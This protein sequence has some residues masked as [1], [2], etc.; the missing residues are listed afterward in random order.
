MAKDRS[1]RA[2]TAGEVYAYL[3]VLCAAARS[4]TEEGLGRWGR[5][6]GKAKLKRRAAPERMGNTTARPLISGL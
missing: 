6:C 2:K 4:G 3:R 1:D 5:L